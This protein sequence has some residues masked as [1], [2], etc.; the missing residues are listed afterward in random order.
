MSFFITG[1]I[2]GAKVIISIRFVGG[3]T[4]IVLSSTVWILQ[5]DLF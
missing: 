2:E 1:W 5:L 4:T 3:K